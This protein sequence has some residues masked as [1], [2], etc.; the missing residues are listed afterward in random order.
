MI[1]GGVQEKALASAYSG[2]LGGSN[3]DV[4]RGL[5]HFCPSA[6]VD[7]ELPHEP[8]LYSAVFEGLAC[9]REAAV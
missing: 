5:L 3:V 9:Y 8:Q 4:G 6:N 2:M 1:E 7:A